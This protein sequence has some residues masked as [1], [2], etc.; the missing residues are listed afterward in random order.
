[1]IKTTALL[2]PRAIPKLLAGVLLSLSAVCMSAQN[3]F[4]AA[5]NVGI[6]TTTPGHA[7]EVNGDIQ[8]EGSL[9]IP[10]GANGVFITNT[11]TS[12]N[13]IQANFPYLSLG[14][15]VSESLGYLFGGSNLY[16]S[17]LLRYTYAGG[18]GS[19]ANYMGLAVY[20]APSGLMV[21]G[22]GNVG[23]GTTTPGV[24]LSG[25]RSPAASGTPILEVS[26]DIALTQGGG[27]QVYYSD[28]TVQSTAWNGVLSGGDYAESVNVSGAREQY[29]PGDVIVIDSSAPGKF[30]KSN[31]AYSTLVSGI[32]STKPGVVGRRQRTD[33]SQ[34][35][36]EMPMAMTGIVPTKVSAEN[37]PIKIGDLLVASSTM[38]HAMK[39]TDRSLL[40]GAVIGKALGKLDAGTGVI[41]VLVTLQ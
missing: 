31:A 17:G 19:T 1:M 2:R 29:E 39:G 37:G 34:M 33:R 11:G 36:N 27:G 18:E 38:G 23:I 7:L 10:S 16:D 25:L 30:L 13:V 24:D 22:L 32:Y 3:T 5:G 41:E 4:P 28:G 26:G 20:G 6:G 35:K 9:I 15:G 8:T 21:N 12:G 40:T 14:G